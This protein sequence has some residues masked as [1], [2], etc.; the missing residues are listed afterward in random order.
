MATNTGAAW[1]SAGILLS[2]IVIGAGTAGAEP[3][4]DRSRET[5]TDD[6]RTLTITKSGE[7]LDR[8]PG[9]V[10]SPVSRE[11]FV[12]VKATAEVTGKSGPRV[13]SGTITVG[14]QIGCA[15]DVSSGLNLGVGAT[16]GAN[17]GVSIMKPPNAGVTAS[18]TP[19]ISTSLKPGS[20]TTITLGEKPWSESRA[21]IT[22]EQVTVKVD[23]CAGPVTLRS[24]ATAAISTPTA[25]NNITVYGDAMQL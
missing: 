24:F 23:A 1:A 6:G 4:A 20:I 17:A 9:L 12:S 25:D 21:S 10:N 13:T 22:A 5:V 8:S 18:V 11:G 15:V 14:Y 19:N 7:N 3:V 16:L 2:T